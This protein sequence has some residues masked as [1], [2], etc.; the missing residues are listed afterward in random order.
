M[1]FPNESG[2]TTRRRLTVPSL[3]VAEFPLPSNLRVTVDVK[4]QKNV[5]ADIE[6]DVSCF[7]EAP[8]F[9]RRAYH[10]LELTSKYDVVLSEVTPQ[11]AFAQRITRR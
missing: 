10:S 1:T 5:R 4:D 8:K 9:E 3:I 11:K 7:S 2:E 6:W